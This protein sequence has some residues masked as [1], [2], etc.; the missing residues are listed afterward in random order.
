M[1]QTP[2]SANNLLATLARGPS[3]NPALWGGGATFLDL[4]P[5]Q[6]LF[7]Q[8]I[9]PNCHCF[10][11]AKQ[12]ALNPNAWVEPVFGTPYYNDYR[13]QRQP[14]ESMAFGRAFRLREG[15]SLMVRVEF[16]NIFNRMFYSLPSVGGFFA[17]TTSTPT[18]TNNTFANGQPGALS[19]GY[20][21]VNTFNG[22]GAQPH[23]GQVV[24]RLTF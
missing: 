10:D 9:D 23:S 15:M 7:M 14:A 12:L 20:G 21:F 8:G 13:W 17:T 19:A 4:V 22:A 18:A 11:P 2:P 5:G 3:N 1:I 24:A 6:P 16:Q